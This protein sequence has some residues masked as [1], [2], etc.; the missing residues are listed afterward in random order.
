[1]CVLS[2]CWSSPLSVFLI[3]H[4]NTIGIRR[5]QL[6]PKEGLVGH[7]CAHAQFL[8]RVLT[9]R[10]RTHISCAHLTRCTRAVRAL[11]DKRARALRVWEN[12]QIFGQK[13]AHLNRANFRRFGQKCAHLNR[14]DVRKVLSL[15][16]STSFVFTDQNP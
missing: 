16:K 12:C 3:Y 14:A 8:V 13:C 6:G 9:F 7:F 4:A 15:K 2:N 1:M 5:T 10:A 11:A